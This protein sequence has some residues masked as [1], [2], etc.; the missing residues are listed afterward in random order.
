MYTAYFFVRYDKI[1][2]DKLETQEKERILSNSKKEEKD[3][4]E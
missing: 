4:Y 3:T 2:Y 1:L